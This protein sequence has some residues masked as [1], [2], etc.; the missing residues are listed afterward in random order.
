MGGHTRLACSIWRP[1]RMHSK[2]FSNMK[3]FP[4]RAPETAREAPA[5][6]RFRLRHLPGIENRPLIVDLL[7]NR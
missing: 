6:P 3:K 7:C 5:L 1:R 2:N 4:A